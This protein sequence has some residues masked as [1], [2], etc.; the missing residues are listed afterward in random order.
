MLKTIEIN[1]KYKVNDIIRNKYLRIPTDQVSD[2]NND[3]TDYI[4]S[5]EDRELTVEDD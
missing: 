1:R 4:H 5:Q 2:E 3:K